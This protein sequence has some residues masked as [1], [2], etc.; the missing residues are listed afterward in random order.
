M[1][2]PSAFDLGPLTWVKSEIDLALDRAAQALA[3]FVANPQD[4]TQLKFCRTH[5]HQVRGALAI[6]GLDGVT[7]FADALESLLADIEEGRQPAAGG[8]LELIAQ[9]IDATRRYLDDLV[10]GEANQPLRLH[11]VLAQIAVA[12]GLPPP[13]GSELFFPDLS[14]RP[15]LRPLAVQAPGAAAEKLR[16]ARARFQ[17]GLLAWLKAP[18]QPQGAQE[19]Q[20]AAVEIGGSDEAPVVRAFWWAVSGLF[21]AV[22]ERTIADEASV[23]QLLPR[24]DQQIRRQFE[25]SRTVPERLMRDVLYHVAICRSQRAV[26][27][28]IRRTYGLDE[29]LPKQRAAKDVQLEPIVK[30]L[31]EIA[32]IAEDAWSKF[33]GG[34]ATALGGFRDAAALMHQHGERL[35]HTDFRRLTQALVAIT[36]WVAEQPA[37]ASE[38]LALEVATAVLVIGNALDNFAHIGSDFVHQVDVTV[39]RL[40]ACIAGTPLPADAELPALDE[41]TR[42]AQERLLIAQVVREIQSNLGQIEQALDTFFRDTTQRE[43][44]AGLNGPLHQIE[45]ALTILGQESAVQALRRSGEQIG[46]F[47]SA[48]YVA[49]DGDFE[50]VAKQLSA[51]GFFVESLQSGGAD[52]ERFVAELEAGPGARHAARE[53]QFATTEEAPS[54]K[55]PAAPPEPAAVVA[56]PALPPAAVTAVEPPAIPVVEAAPAVK[57][58]PPPA[59]AVEATTEEI[60]A[61]LLEIFLEEAQEVLATIADSLATLRAQPNDGEALITVRRAFHTLKGSSRMVGLKDFGEVAWAVEQVHNQWLR[62]ELKVSAE[63]LDLIAGAH[64]I[65]AAWVSHL[66]TGEAALPDARALVSQADALR[67]VEAA[68][69]LA[70]P[71]PVE[72]AVPAVLPETLEF[73]IE[74]A[75][76]EAAVAPPAEEALPWAEAPVAAPSAAPLAEFALELPSVEPTGVAEIVGETIAA[77]EIPELPPVES[78]AEA[79]SFAEAPAEA[80]PIEAEAAPEIPETAPLAFEAIAPE[81]P[82]A[83]AAPPEI[84]PPP[85]AGIAAPAVEAPLEFAA[86]PTFEFAVEPSIEAAPLVSEEAAPSELPV[87]ETVPELP[88]AIEVAAIPAV[89]ETA[90]RQTIIVSPAL[91]DI[92]LDEARTHIAALQQHFG[93]LEIAP[94]APTSIDMVRAA[95]TLGSIA[96]TVGVTPIRSLGHALEDAL[97]RRNTGDQR[98]NLQGLETLRLTIAELEQMLAE[99]TAG[100]LPTDRADLV[101]ALAELYPQAGIAAAEAAPEAGLL[102]PYAVEPAIEELPADALDADLLPIFL[103]EASDLVGGIAE[104]L[105][106]WRDNPA[107]VDSMHALARHLHTL[108]GSARMAGANR[109]GALTHALESRVEQAHQAGGADAALVADLQASFDDMVTVIDGLRSGAPAAVAVA[110]TPVGEEPE[111]AVAI[112]APPVAALPPAEPA[113]LPADHLDEQLLPIFLEEATELTQ[114]VYGH[115]AA[116]RANPTDAQAAQGLAR[117]LH[118]IKG[119]ARMAGAMSLGALTHTLESQIEAAAQAGAPDVALIDEVQGA[120][121]T[122]AQV[123][124]HLRHGENLAAMT[125]E[126]PAAVVTPAAPAAEA[127]AAVETAVAPPPAAPAAPAVKAREEAAPKAM[128]RVRADLIDRLVNDAGE[129]SIARA[130]IEG[131]MRGLKQSLL[132]LTENVIR[133]RRQLREVEIQ[134][135]SQMQSKIALAGES[136]T[137]FDPLE[138]DRFTRFQEL[139]RMMAESVNDVATV[140]QNLLKN[141]DEANA[142]LLAQARLNRELQ[143][144]LMA[145]RMVPFSSITERLYRIVRQTAKELGKRT[146]FEIRGSQIELDQ[147]VINTM[148]G[149][150]EHLLRNAIA[151]GIESPEARR[152]AGKNEMGAISLT[153]RQEGNEVVITM[154]DDGGGLPY[155]EIRARAI[156]KGLLGPDEP[157]DQ[158]RLAELIFESGFSTASQVTQVSGRGVGM[159]VVKTEVGKLGGRIDLSSEP[160]RGSDFRI[161]LPLTL[162]V[163]NALIVRVGN[164]TYAIPALMIDQVQE[165]REAPLAKWRQAGQVEWQ[166]NAYPFHFLPHLLA[167]PDALPETRRLY[168]VLL[169]HSG[170]QR[171]AVQV[172]ELQGTQEI[173]V[174]NIGPQLARVIGIAGATVLGDGRV[175][176]ILNPVALAA[177]APLA[178]PTTAAAA[179]PAAGTPAPTSL[180]T[181]LVVDDSLTVRKITGRLL[182]REGYQVFTAKDGVDAL[183]QLTEL[184]PDVIV[185]DIEM[186]RMDGFE[187]ARNIRNDERLHPI[188]I[189]MITSRTAEKHRTHAR[190][191]GVNNYLGKPYQEEELLGL[192]AGYIAARRGRH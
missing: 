139:T 119:S 181:V 137:E 165:V 166:G 97:L 161:Y 105:N 89:E 154:S 90:A 14:V 23:K 92:F 103:E 50:A 124:E 34:S 11:D 33:C 39:A 94:S 147:N 109:L 40:H 107:D 146:D 60:D 88:P 45:G 58:A 24:I 136:A 180:P 151:H 186:P 64:A 174:K 32:T 53:A 170:A 122:I 65:F 133:L 156:A 12:R 22:A 153:L 127:V 30:R 46:R 104:R 73:T 61:E 47:A 35:G 106:M 68:A 51:L 74:E 71:A 101:A 173:V 100:A 86:E 31:R 69:P 28:E 168:W 91:Y 134:A 130:R 121:D 188:P 49:R 76:T 62:Q 16:R 149:P 160:G 55:A 70:E 48:D 56:L 19:L 125:V 143:Q 85:L 38:T 27:K 157:A 190:E 6:V 176:L 25:G 145:V 8:R 29:L 93:N 18:N 113:A 123:I 132:D 115:L 36:T 167:E 141:L 98:D 10:A 135:E 99:V 120:F 81:P 163:T 187:L 54:G 108:K 131:E 87:V 155:D 83:F 17:K 158:R 112:A 118:T 140:Q 72:A 3:Q 42:R 169:L 178:L 182:A 26:V 21:A 57:A 152:A 189:I 150:F 164:R 1:N 177:R 184:T 79:P 175:V 111:I 13:S 82:P 20:L 7:T 77:P 9:A 114:A 102:T 2:S 117:A 96:G 75:P 138:L 192:V 129:L 126:T 171:I 44:L 43:A 67:G 63:L 84:A 95:H 183:E 144:Q 41:M 37:R 15:A 179:T 142:G 162:A 59:A 80:P 148:I 191:I 172:D 128:L 78:V 110:P 5:L 159:D 116:L 4:S 52:Y 185:S 66:A